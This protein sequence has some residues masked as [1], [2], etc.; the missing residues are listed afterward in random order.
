VTPGAA[1]RSRVF[2]ALL[3]CIAAPGACPGD[4]QAPDAR[5]RLRFIVQQQCLPH[6]L[7]DHDPAPCA[8]VGTGFAL[9]PDRKGGAHFLLI[10]SATLGGIE[11]PEARAPEAINYFDAAWQGRAALSAV[12]GR[13]LPRTAVGLAV[14]SRRARS[15]DQLHI[16][17]SCLRADVAHALAGKANAIGSQW[18]PLEL[19][20]RDY[21]AMRLMGERPGASN[22][23]SLLAANLDDPVKSMGEFTLLLAGFE[24]EE[25]PGF[26]LLAGRSVPGAELMLDPGCALAPAG[27]PGTN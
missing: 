14:N 19:E 7:H 23:F 27:P 11:S 20:G 3:G 6:W 25:G 1:H 17:V 10:P 16:H 4:E 26:V 22:P 2:I 9:L 24:F 18:R 15:Q 8:S 12:L 13:A 5:D 21:L